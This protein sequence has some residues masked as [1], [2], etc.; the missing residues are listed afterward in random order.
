MGEMTFGKN[1]GKAFSCCSST[2]LIGQ[3][4]F[5]HTAFVFLAPKPK[6][7]KKHNKKEVLI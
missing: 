7:H 5:C 4:I 3:R 6:K 2:S 1:L